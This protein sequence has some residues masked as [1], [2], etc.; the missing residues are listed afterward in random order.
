[1]KTE[2]I[3]GK[4]FLCTEDLRYN[5]SMNL[6]QAKG[7][8]RFMNVSQKGSFN[9]AETK[10]SAEVIIP[11]TKENVE[12]LLHI[13][14]TIMTQ[15][16]GDKSKAFARNV[17]GHTLKS[18]IYDVSKD[19][20]DKEL[21]NEKQIEGRERL[22]DKLLIKSSTKYDNTKIL[23]D[24]RDECGKVYELNK[25]Q[26]GKLTGKYQGMGSQG[27]I[28]LEPYCFENKAVYGY[29]RSVVLTN[30]S[31]VNN[32]VEIYDP[33]TGETLSSVPYEESANTGSTQV[34]DATDDY[35]EIP[36]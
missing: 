29:L 27:C 4:K 17:F 36:F 33:N 11:K 30:L 1:M 15:S 34:T 18:F 24:R 32:E 9:G 16:L 6:L 25:E 22:K 35:D 26:Y 31:T 3:N 28:S 5:E 13:L 2:T 8:F 14:E 10:F 20:T 21:L 12:L 19:T 23:W 7:T